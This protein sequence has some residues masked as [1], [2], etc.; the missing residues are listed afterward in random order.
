MA[1]NDPT[2]NAPIIAPI[3]GA[4]E[5]APSAGSQTSEYKLTRA[6]V[7]LGAVLQT[8]SAVIA[9]LPQGNKL[10]V[11]AGL[12]CGTGLQILTALGY[13]NARATVK[14]ASLAADAHVKAAS[15]GAPANPR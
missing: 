9:A 3:P 2:D 7:A 14:A 13:V 1:D 8:A 5:P 11:I 15:L 10:V 12:V 4:P 6:L